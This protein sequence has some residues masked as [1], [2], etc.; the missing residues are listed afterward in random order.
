M[1]KRKF[2]V[3]S[4]ILLL[5]MVVISCGSD[6][7]DLIGTW[8]RVSDFD[9]LARSNASSFT[10]GNKGYLACGFD[11]TDRLSDF[12]EYDMDQDFWTQKATFPGAA[13]HSA[14]AFALNEKGY[15]GTGYNGETKFNDF[16]EY[17]PET[18]VWFEKTS[19]PGLA[20]Y[21]AVAFSVGGKGY[22]GC[23]YNGNYLKDFYAFSPETNSWEQI[24]S[25]GGSKRQDATAFVIDDVAYVCCGQNNGDYIDDFWK[26]DPSTAKWEQLRDIADTS[27]DSYD[28]D[29]NI[30]RTMGVAFVIDGAAYLTCGESGS[31]R[32]DSWK[33]YPET[34]LWENVAKFK[35]TARTATAVFSNG[36]RGYVVTG[37]SQNYRFD[38]IWELHPYEYD[39]DDY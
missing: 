22:I 5:P 35:G 30:V 3:F 25:I 29:Y 1:A 26:Y 31:V 16:W 6:D 9:G 23:G 13:R 10:I 33:Y 24:V 37:K 17:N 39:E 36:S 7:D 8:Y 4:I 12:W 2:L 15:L 19:Y 34:D 18:N 32:S 38:D 11:G 21:G 27:D 28:D 20:R 14:V